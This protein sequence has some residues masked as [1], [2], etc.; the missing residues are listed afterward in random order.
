MVGAMVRIVLSCSLF[1]LPVLA[2]FVWKYPLYLQRA[3][4]QLFLSATLLLVTI[5]CLA[6]LKPT[7]LWFWL[8]PLGNVVDA[9][10]VMDVPGILGH[11]PEVLT[12]TARILLTTAAVSGLVAY[13]ICW[14]NKSALNRATAEKNHPPLGITSFLIGP[15]T[16]AY[17]LLLI[18]RGVAYDRYLLPLSFVVLLIALQLYQKIS[19]DDISLV[20]GIFIAVFALF[21]V[22]SMHDNFA[23]NR[24][25]LAATS[26][27]LQ[28]GIPR[29]EIR[30]GFEYD[31]WTELEI[32][33]YVNDDRLRLPVGSLRRFSPPK[34]PSDCISFFSEHTP[35][36]LGSYLL[37]YEPISCF[38]PTDFAAIPYRTWL[39]PHGHS[40]LIEKYK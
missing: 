13:G 34:L 7:V 27:L 8:L 22:A 38:T 33:G 10:G 17:C 23:M 3:R 1:A 5:F 11:K 18:T 16:I 21:G 12:V 2:A 19:E 20:C 9:R 39:P 15:F 26:E 36:V 14:F 35:S 31:A 24:A 29:R 32:S 28:A 30:A 37:T 25:R 4:K 6:L 40:I